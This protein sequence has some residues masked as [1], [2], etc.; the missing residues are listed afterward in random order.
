MGLVEVDAVLLQLG[1]DANLGTP[2][3]L[4][5]RLPLRERSGIPPLLHHGAYDT[6]PKTS[7]DSTELLDLNGADF[8]S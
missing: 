8:G 4:R 2:F 5:S 7:S 1:F 3:H 6:E